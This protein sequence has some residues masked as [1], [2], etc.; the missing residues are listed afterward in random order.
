MQTTE[1]MFGI[2]IRQREDS[3]LVPGRT[4][5]SL[6][7]SHKWQPTNKSRTQINKSSIMLG[8]DQYKFYWQ[9]LAC[10][11]APARDGIPSLAKSFPILYTIAHLRNLLLTTYYLLFGVG[12]EHKH[13]T[14]CH[15]PDGWMD[16]WIGWLTCGWTSEFN[17]NN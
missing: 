2:L 11:R 14:V 16:G 6:E 5:V 10:R 13:P 7:S 8:I 17:E 3:F 1:S 12:S 9:F 15:P 4:R